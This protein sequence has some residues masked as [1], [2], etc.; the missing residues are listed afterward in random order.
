MNDLKSIVVASQLEVD[1]QKSLITDFSEYEEVANEWKEK[2]N[3]IVVTSR[4]QLTEMEMAKVAQK[5]FAE[6]RIKIE[7]RRK[8]LKESALRRG[9]AIDAIAR[10]LQSLIAPIE[11]HL[12]KQSDFIKLDDARILREAEE[13]RLKAEEEARLKK[14]AEML[15]EQERIRKENERLQKEAE[16]REKQMAKERADAE[17]RER[18]IKEKARKVAEIKE[19]QIAKERL[20]AEAKQRELEGIARKEAE[21]RE[22]IQKQ[23]EEKKLEEKRLLEEQEYKQKEAL[24]APDREKYTKYVQDLLNIPTPIVKD[25]EIKEKLK[26]IKNLLLSKLT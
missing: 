23:L 2:A 1:T 14:E 7:K 5:K 6:M 17:E 22:K 8:D 24:K 26:S 21:A 16:A 18:Q 19:E 12:K 4:S 15:A 20:E 9:Q 3:Q 10:Y 25:E 11:E 13:A